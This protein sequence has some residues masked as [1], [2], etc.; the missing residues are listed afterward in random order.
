MEWSLRHC[1][2]PG[3]SLA[4]AL[5]LLRVLC[6]DEPLSAAAA[7][8]GVRVGVVLDLTSDVGRKNLACISMAL[9]DFYGAGAGAARASSS[10]RVVLRVRDSSGDV[11]TAAHA[12]AS[13]YSALTSAEAEYVGYLG[14]HTLTPILSLA[15]VSA[16]LTPSLTPFFL[17]TAPIAS[18]Q[19][20]L[21]AA[22]LDM[23]KWRTAS[24]IYEDSTYG[25]GIT[26]ELVYT[27]QG[28]STRITDSLALP[29]D[30]TESYLDTLL[31]YLKENS[32]RVFIVHMLPDLAARVFHR[33]SVANM[34]SDGYVWIATAGIGSAV[35]SLGPDRFDD[36]QG[37]VTF[38]P[39]VPATDRLMNFTV[40]SST[41]GRTLLGA[42]LNTAF[43]G[44]AGRFRLVNGQLQ[45]STYEIVNI[46]GKS[47]RTVG[48]WT[49]ESGI[50]KDLKAT[51]EKGIKQILWPG[52]LAIAPRGWS[53][54]S[55]GRPLRVAVPARHGF[56]Q[57][58]EVSY[59]LRTNTSFVT[60]YCIDVFDVLMKN[61]P[62]LVAYQYVPSTNTSSYENLPSMVFEKKADV[63]VGDTTIS[64]SRMNKVT[65]TMPFTDTGLSMIVVPKKDSSRSMW[66]FLQPL[67]STLWI[68]SLAFFFLTGFVVWTIEHRI[69]PEFHGTP[70]QQFG[71]IFYFTFS[72]L[73]FSHKEKLESN[74][75]RFVVIIWVFV[76]LILT[77]SYTASLTS[78]L[79]VQRLQPTVTSVQDL[80]RNGDRVGYQSGSTVK[81]WLEEMG[82]NK[83]DL[84]GY[85]T[86][87]EYAEALQRGSGNGGV[88][89]IVDEVPYLKIFLSKYCE[90]YTMVGPT[91]KLGGFG[92]AIMTPAVQQEMAQI[93]KK[94]FGDPGACESKSDGIN[95]SRL[96]FSN[97]GGLFLITGMTSGLA[98]LISLSIFVYQERD[99]LRAAASRT[100]SMSSLQRLHT[101]LER[102]GS[103]EHTESPINHQEADRRVWER[104]GH[105]SNQL[106]GDG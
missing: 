54:S 85:V 80:L 90:G 2:R 61:L 46:I 47:A 40:S 10:R 63:M 33:A 93:E 27:L 75:S 9:D 16:A 12:G 51:N 74:L 34:M 76:V 78:M 94:W 48:F 83:K 7:V 82:F 106:Q 68:T 30:A 95:S 43:D 59:S 55:T 5:L 64:M 8:D 58:V 56:N 36:M 22:I 69:N 62:Y 92:F 66:I 77:S 57:L 67:T 29:I 37:V 11:V 32:T 105:W 73:V 49:P 41:P 39:Y 38:R 72:T 44:L 70:W 60:G 52:D 81:Y 4:L 20:E 71:I 25:A 84:L 97:F 87:E 98:L 1:S 65:F 13:N 31:Y 79:T 28:Y 19:S 89:A 15:P 102:L 14:N 100:R 45:L 96:S 26:P 103:T 35:D 24:L 3:P 23:F 17:H 99:K 101:W 50:F 21:I 91:Y 6:G 86:V 53:M 88:S 18:S 104:D 42:V